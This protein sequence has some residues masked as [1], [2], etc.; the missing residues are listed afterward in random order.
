LEGSYIFHGISIPYTVEQ[1]GQSFVIADP[2]IESDGLEITITCATQDAEIYYQLDSSGGFVKYTDAIAITADTFVE[3]YSTLLAQT[4]TT[5]SA[6]CEYSP[7]HDYSKDYLTLDVVTDGTILWKQVGSNS[8][9]VISYSKDN[10]TTWTDITATSEGTEI[11][12]LTGDKV[13]IKGNNP[14]Y[15]WDKNSYSAFTGGTATYNVKGNIMSLIYGD[16]FIGQTALTVGYALSQVFNTSNIVSAEYLVLP[17]TTLTND[18][19]RSTF[20]HSHLLTK[21]PKI[22]PDIPQ[23][24]SKKYISSPMFSSS[25]LSI[26][27]II[28]GTSPET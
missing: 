10:G 14:R 24:S 17:A 15:S 7:T 8:S 19:Y 21:S 9:K 6:T 23:A 12:V 22:L 18:C 2:V 11:N 28:F 5:V 27:I 26:S 16:N 13:L 4:S 3:A 1:A 25:N 20:A